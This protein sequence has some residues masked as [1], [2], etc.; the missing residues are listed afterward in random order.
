MVCNKR[1]IESLVKAGAFDSMGHTRRGLMSVYDSAVDAV[2]DLK[3]NEAHGQDDLF[4]DLADND[5]VL[6]GNV[7]DL[8]DWDKRTKLAFEREMLGLYVSD[9]P[10]QGLD[11]VLAAERDVG[12]GQ[13]LAEDGPREGQVTIA[14]MITSVTRKTSR[15]GDIWAVITVEDLEASIEV[16]LFP[17][18]Y[19]AV[20]TVL[21]TD[22]VVKV[23]GRVKVDDETVMLNASELSLPDVSEAPSGPVVISLPA[24]RC[25]PAVL[26]QLREVL[27]HHP[28]M[29][30]VRIRLLKPEGTPGRPAAPAPGDALATAD[31]RPEG[32]AGTVVPGVLARA[33]AFVLLGLGLGAVAGVGWWAV[34]DLPAFVVN[35]D[36]RAS[37][38]ERGLTEFL[39]G[40]AWF[41]AL[42][43]VVGALIGL[44]AGA[45]S[46]TW[47]GRSSSESARW[48]RPRRWSAGWSATSWGRGSSRH[49]W[50][51]RGPATWCR[52]S[53][54]CGPR[55]PCWSGPSSRWCRCCWGRRSVA[56]TRS[57]G[58]S[59]GAR[60][61]C[62][63][64]RG[65]AVGER[66]AP[67]HQGTASK[68]EPDSPRDTARRALPGRCPGRGR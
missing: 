40:D 61:Q 48:P 43:L 49:G 22:T 39:G 7:P 32:S 63:W 16:L 31:G 67:L 24:V 65:P 54:P 15:R 20:A 47:D 68:Q 58:R 19:D 33:V 50:Q 18:A 34:V 59:S 51:P 53:S 2:L 36:G 28:G 38:S 14:G 1:V 11:H 23:K 10:L 57:R 8:P 29:T 25:T 64:S 46:A 41:C 44:G 12:I 35:P 3:R 45:G 21:A 55:L 60:W 56:T 26:D 6:T 66:V 13:L 9:H 4:G 42:G 5:P 27:A 37:I 30:E 52:S 17:K 62:R